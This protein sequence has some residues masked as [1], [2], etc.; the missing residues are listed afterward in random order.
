MVFFFRINFTNNYQ[1][2]RAIDKKT[3]LVFNLG[4]NYTSG[5]NKTNPFYKSSQVPQHL[6]LHYFASRKHKKSGSLAYIYK[7][8]V[9]EITNKK[10]SEILFAT[11]EIYLFNQKRICT[12]KSILN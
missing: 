12:H 11:Q 9:P 2:N 4:H 8:N 7:K 1:F 6:W 10:S 3:A 5:A